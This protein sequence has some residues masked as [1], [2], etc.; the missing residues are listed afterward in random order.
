MKQ[1]GRSRRLEEQK[2]TEARL[3][4]DV[5]EDFKSK[6]KAFGNRPNN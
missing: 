4:A 5:A 2:N 6:R 3:L 1:N